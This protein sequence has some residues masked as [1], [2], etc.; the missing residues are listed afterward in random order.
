MPLTDLDD[1]FLERNNDLKTQG[2]EISEAIKLNNQRSWMLPSDDDWSGNIFVIGDLS[3]PFSREDLNTTYQDLFT[4]ITDPGSPT[5]KS[6]TRG[7]TGDAMAVKL[8]ADYLSS[9]ERSFRLR[10][11][12]SVRCQTHAASRRQGHSHSSAGIFSRIETFLQDI[13]KASAARNG[14]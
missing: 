8:Q 1:K 11:A 2:N 14:R 13:L 12:S 10:H 7:H 6:T 3:I 9:Q 4:I 5:Q